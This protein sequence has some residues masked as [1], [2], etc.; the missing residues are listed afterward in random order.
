M[1]GLLVALAAVGTWVAASGAG[2]DPGQ[3]YLVAAEPIGAGA[4]IRAADLRWTS[5]DLPGSLHRRAFTSTRGVVGAVALGPLDPGDLLQAGGVAPAAGEAGDRE[6]S[7]TVEADWAVAGTLR[8][9]DRI[10]VYATAEATDGAG[11]SVVLADATIRRIDTSGGD[12]LGDERSQV[13]TVAIGRADDAEA[14]VT[15]ARTTTLTV[16]R[17]TGREGEGEG[18]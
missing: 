5:L 9:G 17:S 3:R 6:V 14:L 15:A 7:F 8:A 12:G 1:G 2:R 16:L 18:G 13:I 4:R 11:S 10:D